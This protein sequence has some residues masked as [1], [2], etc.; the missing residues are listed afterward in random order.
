M[1]SIATIP[2]EIL[3]QIFYFSCLNVSPDHKEVYAMMLGPSDGPSPV[4]HVLL[5]VCRRWHDAA[6]SASYLWSSI[7]ISWPRYSLLREDK[8]KH[9]VRAVVQRSGTALLDIALIGKAWDEVA[10][11]LISESHRWRTLRVSNTYS[12]KQLWAYRTLQDKL[13]ALE[14]LAFASPV[15][16][17]ESAETWKG[18]FEVMTMMLSNVPSL[19]SLDG[20]REMLFLPFPWAQITD[21]KIVSEPSVM[22]PTPLPHWSEGF[23]YCSSVLRLVIVG[24]APKDDTKILMPSVQELHCHHHGESWVSCFVLPALHTLSIPGTALANLQVLLERSGCQLTTLILDVSP[25]WCWDDETVSDFHAIAPQ[26]THLKSLKV[27]LQEKFSPLRIVP[28]L[29][30]LLNPLSNDMFPRLEEF[31]LELRYQNETDGAMEMLRAALVVMEGVIQPT[32]KF[33]SVELAH[34]RGRGVGPLDAQPVFGLDEYSKL[35]TRARADGVLTRVLLTD[36][37]ITQEVISG[38]VLVDDYLH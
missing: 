25:D 17:R 38:H 26:L 22:V 35:Q 2:I 33:A 28:H 14:S 24:L 15:R 19:R 29:A 6:S 10:F 13:P 20:Y 23:T 21:F 32:L 11:I 12:P 5:H 3:Q 34:C 27:F 36:S 8:V 31:L 7:R 1:A 4:Q 30:S 18:Y 9:F 37:D 16:P